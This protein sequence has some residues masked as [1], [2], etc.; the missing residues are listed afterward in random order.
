MKQKA[1][2]F[3]TATLGVAVIASLFVYAFGLLTVSNASTIVGNEYNSTTTSSLVASSTKLWTLKTGSGSL[4][5]VV[6]TMQSNPTGYPAMKIYD[7]TSTM[8]TATARVLASMST[9][10]QT[11]GTYQFDTVFGYGLSIEMPATFTGSFTVTYR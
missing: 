8:A 5:S 2:L 4:G 9:S 3:T 6:V 11:Q 7:A 10:T 1:Y